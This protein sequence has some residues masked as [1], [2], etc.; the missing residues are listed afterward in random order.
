MSSPLSP[1]RVPACAVC[2][3]DPLD[4]ESAVYLA[5][6]ARY[7]GRPGYGWVIALCPA[8]PAGVTSG[9]GSACAAEARRR[10][11]RDNTIPAPSTYRDWLA[12]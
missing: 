3:V 9:T 5:F 7:D 4:P 10:L 6:G 1:R 2:D 8:A 11:A 12:E